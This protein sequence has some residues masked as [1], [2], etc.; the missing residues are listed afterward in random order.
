MTGH[1][2]LELGNCSLIS[3]KVEREELN[4]RVRFLTSNADLGRSE[5]FHCELAER[6]REIS[7]RKNEVLITISQSSIVDN[8][9]PSRWLRGRRRDQ[10]ETGL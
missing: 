4:G 10:R 1:E 7:R 8:E 2:L 6:V 5:F 9:R 3:L